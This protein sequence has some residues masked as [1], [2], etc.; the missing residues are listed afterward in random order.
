MTGGIDSSLCVGGDDAFH[1][2]N[3]VHLH[4]LSLSINVV[5]SSGKLLPVG[6]YT[7][8]LVTQMINRVMGA[9]PLSVTI[10]NEK[11]AIVEMKEDD[12]IMEVSQLIQWLAFWEGQSVNVCCVISNKR[13]L[14]SII[15]V[16]E[17]VQ[18]K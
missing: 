3:Q 18:N 1:E 5:Q 9:Q 4:N 10:V 8:R 2:T 11:E 17:E 6:S 15:Q 12:P 7:E 16:E 14:L 13:S